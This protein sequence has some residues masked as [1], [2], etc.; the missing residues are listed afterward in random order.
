MTDLL[1][2][3]IVAAVVGGALTYV[4]WCAYRWWTR[5][6]EGCGSGCSGCAKGANQTAQRTLVELDLAPSRKP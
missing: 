4:A 3:T 1:Q 6:V 2:S 5:P